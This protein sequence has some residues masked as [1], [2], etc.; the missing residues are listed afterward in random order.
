MDSHDRKNCTGVPMEHIG[1]GQEWI[2]RWKSMVWDWRCLV[3]Y[4]LYEEEVPV[5]FIIC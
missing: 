5:W 3:Q 1:K 2:Q 4:Q